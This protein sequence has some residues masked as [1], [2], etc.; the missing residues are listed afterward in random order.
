M[1]WL[2]L[3]V[4][5]KSIEILLEVSYM[6]SNDGLMVD[7][8]DKKS[9][10]S[11]QKNKLEGIIPAITSP[12]NKEDAFQEKTFMR[13]ADWL[14]QQG[15]HGLYVCGATG[16]GYHMRLEERKAAVEIAVEKSRQFDG[17]TI[18]HIGSG[19]TR[20]AIEL[21]E[22]AAS[23]GAD[24]IASMP[25][26]N[27]SQA[28][29]VNYYSDIARASELPL[30]IYH[31]PQLTGQNLTTDNLM[32]LFDIPSVAGIKFSY[33]D[34]FLLRRLLIARPE[35]A[36]FIGN[37]ELLCPA[38]LYGACGGI[39]MTYNLFPK[40]FVDIYQAVQSKDITRAM[41]LQ[42]Y[43]M[44][45]LDLA[46]KYPFYATFDLLMRRKGFG[47]FTYRRPREVLYGSTANNFLKETEAIFAAIQGEG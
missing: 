7:R 30:L 46:L 47:P 1:N 40:L 28:Q 41:Q 14:Y 12:C 33:N 17:I 25:P 32:E 5:K 36:V 13:L 15:V 22:H 42:K 16:E 43:F 24:A 20:D 27:R 21:S 38:L 26:A 37:D 23:A 45:F 31:I 35:M 2:I 11:F 18:A 34:L 9:V 10:Q 39:G 29:L 19:N 8:K 6:R 44:N 3:G 4:T